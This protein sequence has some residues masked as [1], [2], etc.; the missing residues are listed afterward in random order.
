MT[1]PVA[2]LER[3]ALAECLLELGPD[4]PT[5]CEG[6]TTLDLAAHVVVREHKPLAGPGL[7]L[8]GPFARILDNAMA[9]AR[10]RPYD[11]LVATFRSGP[12]LLWKPVDALFNAQE[13]F[14]HHEDARRGRYD[15]GPRPDAEIA[16]IEDQLWTTLRRGAKL[17]TRGVKGVGVELVRPDGDRIV[18][19]AARP[20]EDTVELAGRPGEIVLYLSGRRRAAEVSMSGPDAAVATLESARLGV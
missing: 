10:Q 1:T 13:Y 16:G 3:A 19:R 15:V 8:G 5:L 2:T 6:W 11:E 7:V 14:I 20:G 18:A 9:A 17:A 12:P 4:A